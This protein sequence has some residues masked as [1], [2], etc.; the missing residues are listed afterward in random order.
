MY[1][2]QNPPKYDDV[3]CEQPLMLQVFRGTQN[4]ICSFPGAQH[5]KFWFLLL[6][7]V[8]CVI[9][10]IQALTAILL[11]PGGQESSIYN[12]VQSLCPQNVSNCTADRDLAMMYPW[13]HL[14][15]QCSG[16]P[17]TSY[18]KLGIKSSV[19]VVRSYS[20]DYDQILAIRDS[21]VS[22]FH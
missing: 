15:F 18:W 14:N 22:L 3:I 10:R 20:T 16:L 5:T 7:S 17:I 13:T 1:M 21:R 19:S 4:K 2:V 9:V 6:F 11:F 8:R 12:Y